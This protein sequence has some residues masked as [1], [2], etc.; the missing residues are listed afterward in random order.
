M[1]SN[2]SHANIKY[3]TTSCT[4][5]DRTDNIKCA[6]YNRSG[7]K[8]NIF[9]SII[10]NV[11]LSSHIGIGSRQM[12]LKLAIGTKRFVYRLITLTVQITVRLHSSIITYKAQG[13]VH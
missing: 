11:S 7:I 1:F 12:F 2:L 13:Q 8:Q 4:V 6:E 5:R 10:E 3:S 9:K